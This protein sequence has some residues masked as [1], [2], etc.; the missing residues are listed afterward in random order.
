MK[1]LTNESKILFFA[2]NIG[3]EVQTHYRVETSQGNP[4]KKLKG[5]LMEVDLGMENFGILLENETDKTNYKYLNESVS[6]IKT[7]LQNISDEHAI[8]VAKV[9]YFPY[10]QNIE[11][12]KKVVENIIRNN[13]RNDFNSCFHIYQYLQSKGYAL[14]YYC[15]IENRI[16]PV[17]EQIDNGWITLKTE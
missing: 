16:I 2:Q 10:A 5:K 14:D 3:A 1:K 8:E 15:P 12:G 17:Q 11:N 7:P 9:F 13:F 4:L 6:I